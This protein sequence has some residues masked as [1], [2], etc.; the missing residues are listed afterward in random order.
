[1]LA[2]TSDAADNAAKKRLENPPYNQTWERVSRKDALK[3]VRAARTFRRTYRCESSNCDDVI[4]KFTSLFAHD[5]DFR[6]GRDLIY[7]DADG[8][9]H[10]YKM[11]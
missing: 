1:M 3:L 7:M 10:G 4:Y 2:Y 6:F 9:Q 8:N 11:L 5:F